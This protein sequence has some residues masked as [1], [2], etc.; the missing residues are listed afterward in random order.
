MLSP[1]LRDLD[2][3]CLLFLSLEFDSLFM[4]KESATKRLVEKKKTFSQ[5][6][7]TLG[8]KWCRLIKH[9]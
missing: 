6:T 2:R 3:F 8:R 4:V 1:P 5:K 9:L 7:K